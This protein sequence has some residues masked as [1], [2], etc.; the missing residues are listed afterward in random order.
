MLPPVGRR[1][2]P[3][4]LRCPL[5]AGKGKLPWTVTP[6]RRTS[7]QLECHPHTPPLPPTPVNHCAAV[8]A[9]KGFLFSVQR[10]GV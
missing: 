2:S 1:Q 3:S 8:L 9:L 7:R 5:L 4:P 6:L 10:R